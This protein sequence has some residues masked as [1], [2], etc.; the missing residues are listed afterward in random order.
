M[1]NA[2]S[3]LSTLSSH[4]LLCLTSSS[5]SASSTHSL[6]RSLLPAPP[7]DSPDP[8]YAGLLYVG[9]LAADCFGRT[10]RLRTRPVRPTAP[11]SLTSS[12]CTN[13]P[14]WGEWAVVLGA[15]AGGVTETVYL[16]THRVGHSPP[17]TTYPMWW[18]VVVLRRL[19]QAGDRAYSPHRRLRRCCES[20]HLLTHFITSH[21]LPS[22]SPPIS[23][24]LPPL[25][26]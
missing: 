26:L 12:V 2:S 6:V 24:R 11:T 9:R 16:W 23:F 20:R 15:F 10:H 18:V 13:R 19:R 3:V 14:R 25:P 21:L 22:S 17:Y 7:V 8:R 1:L 5:T 4:S